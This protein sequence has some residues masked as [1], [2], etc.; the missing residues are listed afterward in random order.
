MIDFKDVRFSYDRALILKDISFHIN[1]GE[2]I[3]IVGPN[4]G[5]KTTLLKLLM[6]RLTPSSGSISISGQSPFAFRTSIGYVPQV[7]HFD[8]EFPLTTIDLVLMGCTQHLSAW[9]Y[10]KEEAQKLAEEALNKVGLLEKKDE[11]F[12]QLSG[13]QARR[14]LIARALVSS[15][16]LLLLDEPTANI[17]VEAESAICD[18]IVSLKKQMTILMVTHELPGIIPHVD[19]VLCIQNTLSILS[20]ES[21]CKH[22]A[23]GIYHTPQKTNQERCDD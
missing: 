3:G 6:G 19:R 10:F 11:L 20:P 15:P 21:V 14:A 17:D 8:R 23:I 9:G 12:G 2:L 13:G 18:L 4:G 1:Q 7:A 5:G 16:S 22:T